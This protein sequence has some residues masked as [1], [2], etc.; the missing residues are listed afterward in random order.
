MTVKDLYFYFD[1]IS[2]YSF[3]AW[4]KIGNLCKHYNLKLIAEPVV[5]GAILSHWDT[6]GPAEIMPKRDYTFKDTLRS[7]ARENIKIN[8]P[9]AHPFNPLLALRATCLMETH[10][11]YHKFINHLYDLC[12]QQ[13]EDLNNKSL[14]GNLLQSYGIENG[15]DKCSEEKT[16]K[17]LKDK[18]DKA[19][20]KGIFGVPSMLVEA[21]IF[22]GNDRFEFLENY[23]QGKDPVTPELLE[24]LKNLPVGISRK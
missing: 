19:V 6:R 17:I 14:I 13:G 2:P 8:F 5:F 11:D 12:W 22:W 24:K 4:K 7:A 9:P 20:E 16:K 21:E 23:I 15:V 3:L 10:N 18:T 1:Y